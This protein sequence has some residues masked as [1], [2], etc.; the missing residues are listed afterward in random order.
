MRAESIAGLCYVSANK[1]AAVTYV[2]LLCKHNKAI[3][4][5]INRYCL[6]L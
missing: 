3:F 6:S 4:C 1:Q 2:R 5:E